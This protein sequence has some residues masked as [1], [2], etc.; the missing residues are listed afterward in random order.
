M[1]PQKI[2]ALFLDIGGVLLTNGWDRNS[3]QK[4]A[5]HFHLEMEEV[6]ERHHLTFDTFESGKL[7]LDEYLHRIVFYE[8]RRFTMEDFK[9]FMFNE[10]KPIPGV[11]DFFKKLK[12]QYHLKVIAVSNEGREL[13]NYRI[14][15]FKLDDLFD[16]FVSSCFVHIRKPD[17][18]IYNLACDVSNTRPEQA[19]CI[20]D[21][22]M[23]IQVARSIGISG[24]YFQGLESAKKELNKILK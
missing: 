3:R 17:I 19:L 7:S 9:T 22:L 20:D 10:S 5:K 4:A 23:F 15:K 11:L 16:A 2:K 6:N 12:K 14:N 21:R 13:N 24:L 1:K 8:K 18:D